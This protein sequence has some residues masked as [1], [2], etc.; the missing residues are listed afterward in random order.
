MQL[1]E[2]AISYI[3]ELEPA[4]QRTEVGNPGFDLYRNDDTGRII[5]LIEVKAMTASL[6]HRPVG[7]SHT[8]FECAQ[9]HGDQYWIYVVEYVGDPIR[10]RI[11]RIR[12]PAGNART[13]TFDKGWAQ[14]AVN[15]D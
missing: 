4:L 15:E 10:R 6:E 1:E 5:G 9:K 7:L 12:N 13:F 14:L 2:E 11:L 3:L 8:Q